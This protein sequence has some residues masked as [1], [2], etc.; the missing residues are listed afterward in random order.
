MEGLFKKPKA[1]NNIK[2]TI[3]KNRMYK[4]AMMFLASAQ[5]TAQKEGREFDHKLA[6]KGADFEGMNLNQGGAI[7]TPSRSQKIKSKRLAKRNGR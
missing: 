4:M 5:F 3:M 1:T 2:D 6:L 7:Y